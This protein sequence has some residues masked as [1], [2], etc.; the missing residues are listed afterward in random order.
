MRLS[1]EA[2]VGGQHSRTFCVAA[3][4]ATAALTCVPY[5]HNDARWCTGPLGRT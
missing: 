3:Q 5:P 1:Q 4:R 2:F